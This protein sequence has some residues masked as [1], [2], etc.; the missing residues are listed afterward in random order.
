MKMSEDAIKERFNGLDK[1][2]EKHEKRISSLEKTYSIMEKMDY[3]VD[4]IEKAVA[5]IDKKLDE[6]SDDKGRKWDKL[7]DYLFYF[8][9]AA[10]LGYV[11]HQMGLK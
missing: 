3:R 10:L 6:Q 8:I 2:L 1:E 9:I 4:Q 7:I 5:S 11:I